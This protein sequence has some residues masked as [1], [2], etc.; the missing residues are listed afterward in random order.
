M[1]RKLAPGPWFSSVDDDEFRQRYFG[2]LGRLDPQKIVAELQELAGYNIP[3][4]LCFEHPPPNPKWCHRALVSAWFA[5]TVG[6]M[7]P[8]FGH[9]AEGCGWRHPKLHASMRLD[10]G[11]L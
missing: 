4:L 3:A 7:V 1:Y 5:D 8:E 10:R 11:R 9:E 2:L 6:L